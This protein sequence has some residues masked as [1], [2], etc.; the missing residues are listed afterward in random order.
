MQLAYQQFTNTG[1]CDD[2]GIFDGF[3][4]GNVGFNVDDMDELFGC[5]QTKYPYQEGEIDGL[6]MEKIFSVADSNGH[7]ENA[8]EVSLNPCFLPL[9]SSVL[10]LWLSLS[11]LFCIKSVINGFSTSSD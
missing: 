1:V 6:F 2:D 10:F 8:V 7:V 3:N 11:K 5:A 9:S 4:P